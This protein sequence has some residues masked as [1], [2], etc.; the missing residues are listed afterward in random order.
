M[1]IRKGREKNERNFK[2][3]TDLFYFVIIA[4]CM[5]PVIADNGY[6][7]S[8]SGYLDS[9]QPVEYVIQIDCA[10]QLVLNIPYDTSFNLYAMQSPSGR[11][12]SENY[13]MSY[14]ELSDLSNNQPYFK[15]ELDIKIEC[16]NFNGLISFV[17]WN[18]HDLD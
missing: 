8:Q 9:G 12:L 14:S 18:S 16:K 3:F 5:V 2:I 15:K 10:A 7:W 4:V 17:Y 6:F 13:I 11:S 1:C